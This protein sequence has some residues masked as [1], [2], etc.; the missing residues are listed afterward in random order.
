MTDRIKQLASIIETQEAG[1]RDLWERFQHETRLYLSTDGSDE[2]QCTR[3]A[4]AGAEYR[5]AKRTLQT[6]RSELKAL[7]LAAGHSR[8]DRHYPERNLPA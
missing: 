7:R 4:D 5:R 2:E 1:L 8:F 6:L 3:S